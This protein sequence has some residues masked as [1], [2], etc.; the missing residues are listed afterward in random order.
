MYKVGLGDSPMGIA[1]ALTGNPR[2]HRELLTANPHKPIVH[3]RGTPT[4]A[5]LGVGERLA[6]PLGWLGAAYSGTLKQGQQLNVGDTL[7]SPSGRFRLTLQPDR[8]LVLYD[9]TNPLRAW[10][11]GG[12]EKAVLQT[13]GN[14]VL[15]RS[16]GSVAWASDVRGHRLVMQDDG[17]LVLYFNPNKAVWSSET[18]GPRVYEPS[19]GFFSKA[20]SAVGGALA[21]VAH[22]VTA[23]LVAAQ[24][25]ARGDNVLSTLGNHFKDQVRNIKDVAP[26]AQTIVSFVPGVGTGVNAAIAA[27]SAIAQGRPITDAVVAAAKNALPGGPAAASAFDTAYRLGKAAATGGNVGQ[28]ALE[29]ARAQLPGGAAAQQAFDT[30]LALAHGQSVQQAITGSAVKAASALIPS[31]PGLPLPALPAPVAA[32]VTQARGAIAALDPKAKAV[33][34][35]LLQRPEL[36]SLPLSTLTRTLGTDQT[37]AQRALASLASVPVPGPP[38]RPPVPAPA[39]ARPIVTAARPIASAITRPAPAPRPIV[40]TRPVPAPA[41]PIVAAAIAPAAY[42][43]YPT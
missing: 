17:N 38:A 35:S 6:L 8:N 36:R 24:H 7:T 10:G 15:Y 34:S 39:P 23:P 31:I 32:A 26:L 20:A 22:L 2:R 18:N 19:R 14:F 3:V 16:D 11:P 37:T 5:S 28:A 25:I 40:A 42:A 43:P 30:A 4:F 21:P 13:D 29:A 33:V 41:R 9:G 27:G 1:G 12:A